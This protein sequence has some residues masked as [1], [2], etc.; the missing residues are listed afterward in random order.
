MPAL[1]PLRQLPFADIHYSYF[2]HYAA[3]LHFSPIFHTPLFDADYDAISYAIFE[4]PA[5][6]ADTP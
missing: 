1:S 2:L 3:F 5:A 6:Y 4:L